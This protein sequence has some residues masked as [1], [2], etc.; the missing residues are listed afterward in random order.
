MSFFTLEHVGGVKMNPKK[1]LLYVPGALLSALLFISCDPVYEP[2]NIS[3]V[4]TDQNTS[5]PVSEAVVSITS[6]SDLAAETFSNES[7]E[8]LFE[9]VAV[10]SVINITIRVE[11]EGY[12]SESITLLAAPEHDLVVPNIKIRNLQQPGNGHDNGNGGALPGGAAS[13]EL[14]SISSNSINIAETGGNSNSAFTFVVLD[15]TG[16]PIGPQRATDVEFRITEG[17]GGGE[18]IT[19]E[20]VRTNDNGMVTSNIY[21]GNIAGNLK[22]EAKIERPEVGL[23]I[24]S[25]PILLTIHGGFPNP[26]HF[27]IAVS[28]FNFEGYTINGVRNEITVILGDKFSNPVKPDTPVYF[29]TTGGVIQGSGITNA[30]GE[31]AVDL[32]SGNPRPTDGYATVRA[33]TFD[34]NDNQL[35]QEALVLFSGPPHRNN[36]TVTPSTFDI[37][38][39][40]SQRFEMTITDINGNPLPYNTSITVEPPDGMTVDG[41][42]NVSV[43]NTLF[44]GEGVTD[45]VFTARDTDNESDQSQEVSIVITVETPGGYRA[46]RTISGMKAKIPF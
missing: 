21:A 17:P 18:T 44:P 11:K 37:P 16:T 10:D 41:D 24:R 39:G 8:Y 13:I 42:V 36:I 15:S 30:D 6:P 14:A 32:I 20:V 26:D 31:V 5:S 19:P 7:G 3:G 29:N 46:T 4:V 38:D 40:G 9:E 28:I 2:V 1:I 35:I 23:T 12:S 33:H 22:I 43:P 45:F 25:K 34:E 27:S